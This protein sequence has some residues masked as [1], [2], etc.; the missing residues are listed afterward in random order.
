MPSTGLA[1]RL[2][3]LW[4]ALALGL[5]A[6]TGL[7]LVTLQSPWTWLWG[8]PVVKDWLTSWAA[9]ETSPPPEDVSQCGSKITEATASSLPQRPLRKLW[10]GLKDRTVASNPPRDVSTPFTNLHWLWPVLAPRNT[11]IHCWI[12]TS[13]L[14]TP[15]RWTKLVFHEV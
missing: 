12:L 2:S 5:Q 9:L 8:E 1:L 14:N 15:W 11:H 3:F 13:S 10:W 4:L 7:R 6:T